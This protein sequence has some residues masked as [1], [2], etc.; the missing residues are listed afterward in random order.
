M[1]LTPKGSN[2]NDTPTSCPPGDG[3]KVG[4]SCKKVPTDSGR[5]AQ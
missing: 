1:E 4:D 2:H 5:L 3:D